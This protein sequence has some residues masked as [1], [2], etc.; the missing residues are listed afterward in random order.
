MKEVKIDLQPVLNHMFDGDPVT[1]ITTTPTNTLNEWLTVNYE[2]LSTFKYQAE[3]FAHNEGRLISRNNP[4]LVIL[5]QTFI[6]EPTSPRQV[7]NLSRHRPLFPG[8]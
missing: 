5:I 3:R 2:P 1:L 4:Y 8:E 7:L 6:I